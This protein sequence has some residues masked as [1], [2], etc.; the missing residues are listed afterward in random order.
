[1][2]PRVMYECEC[3]RTNISPKQFYS[4][5]RK[6]LMEKAGVKITDWVYFEDWGAP[7]QQYYRTSKHED[8]DE[9]AYE[10]SRVMPFD[11]HLYLEGAYNFIMQWDDGHGYMYVIEYER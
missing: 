1:M 5:C 7:I 8:W 4:Y 9:P 10:I 11:Y 2:K 3:N 6:K